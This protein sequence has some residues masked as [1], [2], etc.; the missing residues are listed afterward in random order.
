MPNM[1]WTHYE[2]RVMIDLVAFVF[3]INEGFH[4]FISDDSNFSD[5]FYGN[6]L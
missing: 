2:Q 1:H 4:A 6:E 5:V 3:A